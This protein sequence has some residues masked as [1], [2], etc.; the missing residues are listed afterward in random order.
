ME[1]VHSSV[2]DRHSKLLLELL[3]E[4]ETVTAN[5]LAV[6]LGVSNK[7]I[8]N[9]LSGLMDEIRTH[10]A[11]L[12]SKTGSGYTLV[13]DDP[14]EFERYLHAYYPVELPSD[15]KERVRYIIHRLLESNVYQRIDD[16]AESIYVSRNTITNDLKEVEKVVALYGLTIQ[17]RPNYGLKIVGD[18]FDIRLCLANN[19][20][21][22]PEFRHN[23]IFKPSSEVASIVMELFAQHQINISES[24]FEN[25]MLHLL[26]SIGRIANH[27]PIQADQN[28]IDEI[29]NQISS[30][31]QTISNLLCDRIEAVCSVSF[32]KIER[33]YTSVH[34]TGK[35][36]SDSQNGYGESMVIS[37]QID[38]LVLRMINFIYETYHLDFRR[39]LELRM[40][41]NQHMVPMDIRLRYHIPLHNPLLKQI[42]NSYAYAYEIAVSTC[43]ILTEYYGCT[44]PD[45]EIG[46]IAILIA[47]AMEKRDRTPRKYN[48]VVVCVSGRGTSQLFMYRYRQAFGKYIDHMYESTVYELPQFD[49][50]GNAIDLVF[51]TVPLNFKVPV[52]VFEVSPILSS[53]EID[54]YQKMLEN[55]D[56]G[57]IR[58]YFFAD[59]FVPHLSASGKEEAL[60][61]LSEYV[62]NRRNVPS[63]F[64]HQIMKRELWGQTDFGNLVAIPHA[65]KLFACEPFI[66]VAILDQPIWWG[67]NDVQII[68][69]VSLSDSN[70][71]SESFYRMMTNFISV[72][73]YATALIEKP[74]FDQLLDLLAKAYRG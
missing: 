49:F 31:I 69:L 11:R 20:Y 21:H 2:M 73:D 51:T 34:L 64:Y 70:N 4:K 18:E 15:S 53:D 30:Y 17:R 29:Q 23:A 14:V 24:S 54:N 25:L 8:R 62:A 48:I 57:F 55:G 27:H 42:R 74:T 44:I 13:V 60:S 37:T 28:K 63:D 66:A 36:S 41:L 59:L 56:I 47:L 16:I 71:D 6:A 50:K 26:I 52:P 12:L 72:A 35:I 45:D 3:Q 46:Y 19:V 1:L 68:F 67:H 22:Y 61:I 10:G 33:L 43:S 65:A 9:R 39:N 38:E 32:N 58:H 7:T 40:S 5:E